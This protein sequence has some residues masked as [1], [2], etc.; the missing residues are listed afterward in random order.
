MK[1]RFL[2]ML[3]LV[4]AATALLTVVAGAAEGDVAKI[5]NTPYATLQAAIDDAVDGD[6]VTLLDSMSTDASV[7]VTKSITLDLNGETIEYPSESY[8]AIQIDGNSTL[9]ITDSSDNAEGT[10]KAGFCGIKVEQGSSL[11]VDKGN[12]VITG[13]HA[14]TGISLVG[15][16]AILNGGTVTG[17]VAIRILSDNDN[18]ATFVMNGGKL[19]ATIR[20]IDASPDEVLENCD[21][22]INGGEIVGKQLGI[23]WPA[24]GKLTITGGSITAATAVCVKSGSLEITGGTLIGNGAKY[25][26]DFEI[27]DSIPTGEA[28]V[29]ENVGDSTFYE[30]VDA[31]SVTGGTFISVN[32]AAVGSYAATTQNASA[33]AVTE[34]IAGGIF[35]SDPF[36][37]VAFGHVVSVGDDGYYSV[38]VIDDTID[39]EGKLAAAVSAGGKIVLGDDITLTQT[40]TI[41]AGKSVFLDL[42]GHTISQTKEQ[43]A[44]YSMIV[45]NGTLTITDSAPEVG[46]ISYTD[47]G[48]GGEYVSNTIQN[49][50]LLSIA[51]GTIDNYSGATVAANGYPHVIDNSGTLIITGGTVWC[52][53]YSAIRTWCTTDDDTAVTIAGNCFIHGAVD[54]YNVNGNANKGSLTISGGNFTATTV[55]GNCLRLVNFGTNL[56]NISVSVESGK[57]DGK[58][59]IAGSEMGDDS[60]AA[61]LKSVFAVSGGTFSFDPSDYVVDGCWVT[62]GNGNWFTVGRDSVI[63]TVEELI[64]AIAAAE[65]DERIQLEGVL[66]I[67]EDVALTSD[68]RIFIESH[69]VTD[70]FTVTAGTLTLGSN[71]FFES[72]TSILYAHGGKIFVNNASVSSEGSSYA[73][74]YAD[75]G[76]IEVNAGQIKGVNCN[77][78]TMIADKDGSVV[79]SNGSAVVSNANS[80][81][82]AENGGIATINGSALIGHCSDPAYCVAFARNGGKI[83]VIDSDVQASSGSGLVAVAGGYVSVN[84]GRIFAGEN[85]YSVAAHENAD[86]SAEISGGTFAGEL[87]TNNGAT[88][89]VTGGTFDTDPTNFVA[90]GYVATKSGD[91]WTVEAASA[92]APDPTPTP[93]PTPAPAP[94]TRVFEDV[95]TGSTF[96]TEIEWA[97]N[98]GFVKGFEGT[99]YAPTASISRQQVWMIMAR[100]A[101]A[102]PADMAAAKD[103]A[104]ANGISDGSAPGTAI[105]RQQMVTMLYRYAKTNAVKT[106]LTTYPDVASVAGY[107]TDAMQWAVANGIIQGTTSGTLNPNGNTTRGAFAAILY[108]YLAK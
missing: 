55:G 61:Y 78:V 29:I 12:I 98:Q 45:N 9:T 70:A 35:S 63:D 73:V 40:L 94:E 41:P 93:T 2:A 87:W 75:A 1:K 90:E 99:N 47:S 80:A 50:G 16:S 14:G 43:T 96:V 53:Y 105:T 57:F 95:P 31:V 17:G 82:L 100:A 52:E 104:I 33:V 58:I 72:D 39:T 102:D 10:I 19:D 11:V 65:K 22:T 60:G 106:D 101:G 54:M 21:V 36:D 74:A 46:G 25:D 66:T 3:L 108:R 15:S 86:A 107:A 30:F 48:N 28:L 69:G 77:A 23:F 32:A 13:K 20:A 8:W 62:K 67:T 83:T 56:D 76:S 5:G 24:T 89:T 97:Y 92:P 81:L 68:K 7:V 85:S 84:S 44:A 103:W 79:V 37:Y 18:R 6:T 91:V 38:S 27:M 26:Y 4:I 71:I 49:N 42:N 88:L 59:G 34:F 51:A 64:A